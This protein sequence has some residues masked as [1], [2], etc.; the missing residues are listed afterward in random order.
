MEEQG[1]GDARAGTL[2][3]HY[4]EAVNP[5]IAELAWRDGP[6]ELERLTGQAL[7]WLGRAAELALGRFDLDENLSLLHRAAEL[8][9]G[10][11]RVWQAIGRAN[12]LK[13]DGEAY[14]EAML[15]A[16]EL[17][18]DR[19]ILAE[20]YGELAFESTMRGAMWK[21]HPEDET[22]TGWIGSALE[23]AAPDS[24][25]FAYASIAKGMRQDDVPATEHAISIARQMDDVELLS[26]GLF[27]LFA[28]AHVS[29]DYAAAYRWARQRLALADRFT[30]P[31]HLALIRWTSSTAALA[32]GHL[33]EAEAHARRHEAIAARLSPHHSIHAIGNLLAIAECTGRWDEVRSMQDRTEL[34]VGQNVGT[35]CIENARCLLTCAAACGELGLDA[36]AHRLEDAAAALGFEG[37][38]IWLD[39][40]RARLAMHRGDHE[41]L[42]A[43]AEGSD[44]WH[45]MTWHHVSN[46]A[47]RLETLVALGRLDQ[48]AE[49]A[50]RLVQPDSL[51]EPFALRTL[52][53]ARQDED[54]LARAIERF[55]A[56]GLHWQ[57]SRTWAMAAP[58]TPSPPTTTESRP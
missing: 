32:L 29:S 38:G 49:D 35:P 37:Y 30:D 50:V 16:I 41:A 4:A 23:L 18:S 44:L 48:A 40:L 47:T 3:Y 13:F 45:W 27:T 22:V 7:Q 1:A 42:A 11:V 51:L 31:D 6:E 12:A 24:R 33:D 25:A 5:E 57:A 17:T 54:L 19:A 9:P 46:T 20:L 56:L 15:K 53:L 2:A 28:I 21:R 34:A 52:G 39:P 43:L 58:Q 8:T 14:W 55:E 26:F 36:E 10:A